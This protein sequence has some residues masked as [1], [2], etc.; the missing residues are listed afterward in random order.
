MTAVAARTALGPIELPPT[1]QPI[2]MANTDLYGGMSLGDFVEQES[3]RA[4]W[5]VVECFPHQGLLD[6]TELAASIKG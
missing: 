6:V 3:T 5:V 2:E 1:P 4:L